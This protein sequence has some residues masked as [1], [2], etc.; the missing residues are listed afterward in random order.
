MAAVFCEPVE[1]DE[2]PP[3]AAYILKGF[4]RTVAWF[5]RVFNETVR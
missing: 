1:R 3:A 2:P 4:F 5:Q